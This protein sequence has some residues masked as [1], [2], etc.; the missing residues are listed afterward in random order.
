MEQITLFV[1]QERHR[2]NQT[3]TILKAWIYTS[4]RIQ[5]GQWSQMKVIES[6]NLGSLLIKTLNE[7]FVSTFLNIT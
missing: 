1:K 6:S 5:L 4:D 7:E 3:Q 2:G